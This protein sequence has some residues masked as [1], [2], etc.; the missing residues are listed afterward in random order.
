MSLCR[1]LPTPSDRMGILWCLL[2]VEDAIVL[3]YGPA[4]TT[5]F[6]MVLYGRL[7]VEQGDR[8]YT[9]HMSE[10]DVVMGDVTRLEK[11][12]L[13]VDRCHETKVIFVVASSISAVIGTDIKG[14]CSYMQDQ[15]KAKLICFDHGGLKGDFSMGILE[16]YKLLAKELAEKTEEKLPKTYNII[17]LSMGQYRA[18]SDLW[19]IEQLMQEAF[20]YSD[21]AVLCADTETRTVGKSSVDRIKNMSGAEINIVLREEGLSAAKIL[22][23]KF[24]T[25]YVLG[26]PYGY[27]GTLEW[28][29]E[30]SKVINV[31]INPVMEKRLTEKTMQA[32]Q[33]ARFMTMQKD[34]KPTASIISDY[35]RVIGIKSIVKELNFHIDT[36]ISIHSIKHIDNKD[37]EVQYLTVEKDKIDLLK[38]MKKQI[39]FADDISLTIPDDTNTK[40][41]T[42][43]PFI[44]GSQRAQHMPIVGEKGCDYL[45]EKVD[46]YLQVLK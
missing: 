10:D 9:T 22:E 26:C 33:F 19:E 43:A 18:K 17:G 5:H 41:P 16:T 24:K 14:V 2:C 13:E 42:S 20:G 29:K 36:L 31:P 37:E 11:A 35:E 34:K 15:V 39:I 25:P 32:K 30:I 21:H 44:I 1:Y 8:L 6:S 28:L 46:A 3:E 40:V 45:L 27:A 12:I 38:K 23:K 4:G 7:G